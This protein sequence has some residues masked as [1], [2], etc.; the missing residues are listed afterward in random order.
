MQGHLGCGWFPWLGGALLGGVGLLAV[1]LAAAVGGAAV[2]ALSPRSED[3]QFKAL[4]NESATQAG[5]RMGL[6]GSA[7]AAGLAVMA[8]GVVA[9]VAGVVLVGAGFL[10]R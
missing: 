1:G 4:G 5:L 2:L 9:Q 3:G 7:V 10:L 6:T 8:L